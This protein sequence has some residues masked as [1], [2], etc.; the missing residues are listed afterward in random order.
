MSVFSEVFNDA[1]RP[2]LADQFAGTTSG[3]G[4]AV[5]QISGQ[6]DIA[7]SIARGP[8]RLAEDTGEQRGRSNR[9]RLKVV[10]FTKI[11]DL[12]IGAL[13]KIGEV[14]WSIDD[15]VVLPESDDGFAVLQL[16]R[17][18]RIERTRPGYRV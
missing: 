5:Y 17:T 11:T 2:M 9:R 15:F 3:P 14:Q 1:A 10:L 12:S 16:V 18:A 8:E 4:A 6:D 7:V 13:L